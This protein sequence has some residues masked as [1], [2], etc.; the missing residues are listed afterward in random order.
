MPQENG[1]SCASE[2]V[3][4]GETWTSTVMG[5]AGRPR[6]TSAATGGFVGRMW[7][8]RSSAARDRSKSLDE[9]T[10][11]EIELQ[12]FGRK[13]RHEDLSSLEAP[14]HEGWLQCEVYTVEGSSAKPISSRTQ[15]LFL[16]VRDG[17]L[18]AYRSEQAAA[19]VDTSTDGG[20]AG[21]LWCLPLVDSWTVPLDVGR[22]GSACHFRLHV[23]Q[24]RARCL[25]L[26]GASAGERAA[27]LCAL[28]QARDTARLL[29]QGS[30]PARHAAALS[31]L[32]WS[33]GVLRRRRRMDSW[34]R[35][36][37]VLRGRTLC[38]YRDS[39]DDI[40][41]KSLILVEMK[42]R[43]CHVACM[44]HTCHLHACTVLAT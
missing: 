11:V 35:R 12:D 29:G 16:C 22:T 25:E 26:A 4:P 23:P 21:A 31:E 19:G 13:Q 15:R 27:W 42:V 20:S 5:A 37:A 17:C 38:F 39:L 30:Y 2:R 14:W 32:S 24:L 28:G 18:S 40:V 8:R 7:R 6:S 34:R 33:G 41:L 10:V 44:P 43:I 9:S 36:W 3:G 1:P